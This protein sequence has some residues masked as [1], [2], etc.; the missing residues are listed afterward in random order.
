MAIKQKVPKFLVTLVITLLVTSTVSAGSK[1]NPSET[2]SDDAIQADFFFWEVFHNGL[3]DLIPDVLNAL[4]AAYLKDPNDATTAAYIGAAHAWRLSERVRMDPIPA[5]ITDH[6]VLARKYFEEK[7]RM[8][9]HNAHY[10]GFLGSLMMSEADVHGDT[11][12][13]DKGYKTLLKSTQLYPEFNYVTAGLT[14]TGGVVES[15]PSADSKIFKTALEW[16]WETME[17]CLGAKIDRANPDASPYMDRVTTEGPKKVCWNSAI[18]PHK[19]E[20]FYL[21]MGDMLV[22]SGDWRTAQKI[23]AN[24]K[25]S[26]DYAG[27][28]FANILEERIAE[29]E[30]NVA[31]FNAPPGPSG[32]FA[33]PMMAQSAFACTGCHQN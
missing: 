29:A 13:M 25:L 16:Q 22:K 8:D 10:I 23:Y 20:G 9:P 4:T 1:K 6:A 26:P 19:F 12:L 21:N 17:L 3:Y 7:V 15:L 27:W 2:R 5:T 32:Q 24:A 18:A 33:K 28:Q 31:L 11:K 14:L 30:S